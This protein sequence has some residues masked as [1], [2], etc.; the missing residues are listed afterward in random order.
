MTPTRS[1][2][3]DPATVLDRATP[4]APFPDAPF[5]G[6][7]PWATLLSRLLDREDLTGGEAAWAMSRIVSGEATPA[8]VAGFVTALRAKGETPAEVAGLVGALRAGAATVDVPGT[9]VDIAGTGG[10]R[11]GV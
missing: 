10:D 3:G 2:L 8:Q 6:A 9:T 4:D 11:T 7:R 5:P 1:P